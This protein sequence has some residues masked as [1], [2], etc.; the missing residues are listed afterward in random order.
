MER[1]NKFAIFILFS[2]LFL[3]CS[4][5]F[6]QVIQKDGKTFIEDRTGEKWDITQAVSLGFKPNN[7]EF[8]LGRNA[9]SP[10]DDSLL[11]DATESISRRLRIL[12]VPGENETKAFAVNKLRG[13]EIANSRIDNKPIAAAY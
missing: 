2:V 9:F 8:G 13:H 10:L 7:F 4:A 11:Q 5:S 3:V 1:K 12:G 6:A